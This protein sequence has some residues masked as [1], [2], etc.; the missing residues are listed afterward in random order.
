[1]KTLKLFTAI[2]FVFFLQ[3]NIYSQKTLPEATVTVCENTDDGVNPI[4]PKTTVKVG[5]G[6]VYQLAFQDKYKIGKETEPE[7]FFI[8]WKVYQLDKIGNE[9]YLY[10]EK[11]MTVNSL[12]RRYALSEQLYY[13]VPGRYR[14]YA[15]PV[16]W[17]DA[18]LSGNKN[19]YYGMTEIDVVE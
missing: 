10:G 15:L 13:T 4:N 5:E 19:K 8:D 12:F 16:G 17:S 11:T 2:L 7:Q 14:I 18:D 3:Q 6:V 1:M 9:E